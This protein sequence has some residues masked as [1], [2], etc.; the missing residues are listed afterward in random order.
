MK[1]TFIFLS[2]LLLPFIGLSQ[3]FNP[4]VTVNGDRVQ[5]NETQVFTDLQN[6]LQQFMLNQEWTDD[7]FE[8]NEKIKLNIQITLGNNSDVPSQTYQADVQIQAIRPV[9]NA[10][11]ET[12][13]LNFIDPKWSFS[14]NNSDRLVY[15]RGIYT[16]E[17]VSLLSYYAY[18]TL[19]MDYDSFALLG[20]SQFYE[21]ALEIANYSEQNGRPGWSAFGDK[22]DRYY[23][24][25]DFMDPQF[26]NFRKFLYTYHR[27]GLDI[28]GESPD[29]ARTNIIQGLNELKGVRRAIPISVTMDVFFAAKGAE[30]ANMFSKATK[31]QA[32]EVGRILL[33][34]DPTRAQIYKK[35]LRP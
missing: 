2:F 21:K 29:E 33:E 31:E 20:G 4:T 14:Y 9:Y 16:T 26:E 5:T 22:R 10:S 23:L 35:L 24:A 12:T 1:Q 7:R 18:I 25:R 13:M 34:L 27:L 6:Q 11:Y 17:I 30:I 32:D 8:D 28:F 15:T 19:G 3:E